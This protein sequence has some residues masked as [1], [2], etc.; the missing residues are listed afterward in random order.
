MKEKIITKLEDNWILFI[1]ILQP[2]LDIISYF[3]TKSI[4]NSYTWAIRI[5]LLLVVFLVSFLHSKNKKKLI[6]KVLPFALFFIIHVLNLSRIHQF[7]LLQDTRYF[8]L[9]FQMP[10]LCISLLDYIKNTNYDL[11]KIKKGLCYN[12]AVIAV[13]IFLSYITNTYQYTYSTGLGI[14]GWFS[15]ANT[16]S[17]ILCALTPWALY[18]A[19]N[20][21]NLLIYLVTH[22]VAFLVLFT[23][24]TRA[25]YLTLLASLFVLIFILILSKEETKKL[26]KI[27][28]TLAFIVLSIFAY[29]F[30][31]TS[32]RL[33]IADNVT[34]Q[35]TEDIQN[36]VKSDESQKDLLENI[37]FDNINIQDDAMILQILK[38]SYI[39]EELI[40]IH[41]EQPV[42]N[43]IK[44]Y[45]SA[46]ALSDN[47]LRKVLNAKIQFNDSDILTKILGI[48]YSR[49]S[50]NEL[51]LEND[52][53]AIYYYYGYLGFI[54]YISFILYF[55]V[56]ALI[57]FFKDKSI[58]HDKE[59]I[60]LL[61]IIVLLV[62]GGEYSGAFLRKS[63]AN[64]YLSLYLVLLSFKLQ[65]YCVKNEVNKK[66]I[67]FLLLHLGYGGIETSTINTANAL[68]KKYDVELISFY[69]LEKNQ[70]QFIN[71]NIAIKYL[72]Q[73]GPNRDEFIK[74]LKERNIIKIVKE[75]FKAINIIIK[76]KTLIK[77]EILSS[78]SFAIIST[79]CSFSSLLSKYGRKDII[80][81]AQEHHHHNN[82]KKYINILKNNYKNIDYLFALT[83]GLK[84][85]YTDFLKNNKY[86]KI[87]VVPNMLETN[88]ASPS[89]LNTKN[90]I[91]ICRLHKGKRVDELINIFSQ[92]KDK[93][94]KLYIIGD[95][96]EKFN[97]EKLISDLNLQ[98][99]VIMTGYLNKDEQVNYLQNSSIY[100]M[101]SESEGLPMVLL[102]AMSFGIP[103]IAYKT[104]SGV[105][106]IIDDSNGFVI[107]NRNQ[108]KYLEKLELLLQDSNLRHK[109]SSAC[110]NKSKEYSEENIIKCWI[111]VLGNC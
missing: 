39:Y 99:R 101:T 77:K 79:R 49:I 56:N 51:D 70:A 12:F 18:V 20:Y 66:K 64:I 80:K 27:L 33:T 54:V 11:N 93:D 41:G 58:I 89:N 7:N 103:C 94:S 73:G 29:K 25:C 87:L 21:K 102:E 97:I 84:K 52:L 81:I 62:V 92:I 90:I 22:I 109:M 69:N 98:D 10:I 2:I 95:G 6:L 74:S 107:D 17:M 40:D 111:D 76:K 68:S 36:I 43:A 110:I 24:A 1:I 106:D 38:A 30:S 83:K 31:F 61:F 5:I 67:S 16:I 46:E 19:S 86:T 14:T 45:L 91:S 37:D 8:I 13:S 78:D 3:Q 57:A 48:G 82:D 32:N 44:P 34:K 72:Y 100:A 63:N 9:V 53:Q 60:I 50:A 26:F 23:N 47:R 4:G 15:S 59:Y 88:N 75:G 104:S 108:S 96:E 65:Q 28:I 85:D 71:K 55:I 42:I 35:Y 105:C